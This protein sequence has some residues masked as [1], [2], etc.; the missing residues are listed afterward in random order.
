MA[1]IIAVIEA[2]VVLAVLVVMLSVVMLTAKPL[3]QNP[4][5]WVRSSR[6]NCSAK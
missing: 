1:A 6:D 4:V 5:P 3:C 2:G